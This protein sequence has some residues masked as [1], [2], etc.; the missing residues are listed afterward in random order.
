M[1]TVTETSALRDAIRASGGSWWLDYMDEPSE[2]A[3]R[4][5]AQGL[6]EF[7]QE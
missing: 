2:R 5:A 7:V 3:L 6:D 1:N 4:R